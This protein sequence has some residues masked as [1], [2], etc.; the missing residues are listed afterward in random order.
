[1]RVYF[2]FF[3]FTHL[4]ASPFEDVTPSSS[5][6]ISSLNSNLL[7]EGFVSPLSG[8]VSLSET[9]LIVRG[10]QDLR[11]SRNYSAPRVSG[12]YS[13][14][15][16]K[17]RF[18]LAKALLQQRKSN[19]SVLP[20]LWAGFN[21]NSPN[22]LLCDP[23]GSVLEFEIKGSKG[24]L[25]TPSYGMSNLR[26]EEP[27]AAADPRNIEFMIDTER[28]HIT[29]PDGTE[30][31]YRRMGALLF[32]LEKELLPNGKVLRY[33][34]GGKPLVKIIATDVSDS[35][36]YASLD[37]VEGDHYAG[38]DGR[39]VRFG[40]ERKEIKGKIKHEH[41]SVFVSFLKK[42]QN[43]SYTHSLGYNERSLLSFYD[44]K[45]FPVSFD[46]SQTK[47]I[48]A[49]V[50]KFSTPSSSSLFSYDPPVAGKK[51][52]STTVTCEDG[53]VK[54]YR[55][56]QAL[57]LTA[58]EN[59]FNG[60]LVNQK[61]FSYNDRQ[62]ICSIET[63]D[64]SGQLLIATRY[65]CDSSGNPLVERIEGDFGSFSI[66]RSFSRNRLLKEKR[67]DGLGIEYTYLGNTRLVT[68]K[69]ILNHGVPLRIT[70]YRYDA[71]N[72]LIEEAE[73][74][75]TKTSYTL[76]QK[77]PYLH[78][79]E[80]KE[81]SDWDGAL[82]EKVHHGYDQWGNLSEERHF[83][84]D[85]QLAYVI[86]RTF[87][88]K[89]ELLNETN[90][91]GQT[92]HYE[93]DLRGRC[94]HE[95]PFSNQLSISRTFDAK[96]RLTFLKEGDHATHYV[97][98]TSDELI[99]KKDYLGFSTHYSYDPVH[100][101]PIRIE[102]PPTLTQIRLDAFGR[103]IER[104]D[105]QRA[106]TQKKQN[107]YG[108]LVELINPDGGKE[109]Y[110]Y[111]SNGRILSYTNADG[112]KTSYEHDV[113]G[114]LLSKREGEL[115]TTY[116]Y[117]AYHLLEEKDSLKIVTT[118]HYDLAGRKIEERRAGRV[119]RFGYDS[120][121]FL[122][123]ESRADR[124]ISYLRDVLGRV[125]KK[126]IDDVLDTSWTYDASGAIA[127]TTSGEGISSF[128]YDPYGRLIE[129]IDPEENKTRISFLEGVQ[130]LTKRTEDPRG[131]VTVETTNPHGF[132]LKR[133]IGSQ[134]VEEF[135]YDSALRLTSQDHLTFAY[136]PGGKRV[137][138]TEAGMRS[139]R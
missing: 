135:G 14:D 32:R 134:I 88:A 12:S 1:M 5:E 91:L 60:V 69:T 39:E 59:W 112:L 100:G 77:G 73:V 46:Y 115:L 64:G 42:V 114:R 85:G 68:S 44:A 61:T 49:R 25:K 6:E 22:F 97:Y 132:L 84:S 36:S 92:A 123:W 45:A 105:A 119:T 99:E 104:V 79:V 98:N 11:L 90:L 15:E 87:N 133:T 53:A 63:R 17:D 78:L 111:A 51:G 95:T 35:C 82:L 58:V 139:T 16:K 57:L 130:L 131:V 8:Q 113:L 81:K 116:R 122:A 138:C 27:N 2:L 30:R 101:K 28:A 109:T 83:G 48:E 93:Y 72:N 137:S 41:A 67:E 106:K 118:F 128:Q 136:T 71:A 26:N 127:T 89:G 38:S 10:A 66:R 62:H 86:Y 29:W 121:G 20:H 54:V 4:V 21:L 120:L 13:G 7:I 129:K 19:W 80:W 74:G 125:L 50:T 102:A 9:D 76:Y 40:F 94:I 124:R 34:Y 43:P 47:G 70:T 108:D 52:G 96:G 33:E 18:Y 117:D 31:I 24:V 3:F 103:E 23:N 126:S 55:F 110:S 107:S 75:H 56:N 65:E 37:W